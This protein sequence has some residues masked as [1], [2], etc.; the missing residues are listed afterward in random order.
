MLAVQH[1]HPS[2]RARN[3][4]LFRGQVELDEAED[5]LA[6]L[7]LEW[8][9]LAQKRDKVWLALLRQLRQVR[10]QWL[11]DAADSSFTPDLLR[12]SPKWRSLCQHISHV[13]FHALPTARTAAAAALASRNTQRKEVAAGRRRL[14]HLFGLFPTLPTDVLTLL[15]RARTRAQKREENL[16]QACEAAAAASE[17]QL[18]HE[19]ESTL[20][21][22]DP[23]TVR[24]T[25]E[26]EQ[27]A[28]PEVTC[29][30]ATK[31]KTD[32]EEV[33]QSQERHE[34]GIGDEDEGDEG[35]GDEDEGDE[36]GVM[37]AETTD[38]GFEQRQNAQEELSDNEQENV[39]RGG[40]GRAGELQVSGGSSTD[41]EGSGDKLLGGNVDGTFSRPSLPDIYG[42]GI[43]TP[44]F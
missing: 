41:S 32:A 24:T 39:G 6:E 1:K 27:K 44:L 21:S 26:S 5:H 43:S 15:H 4:L 38:T 7:H 17:I 12:K 23:D 16:R 18:Q 34:D 40:N 30:E 20:T 31:K 19:L 29:E 42:F 10:L 22:V 37:E 8:Y 36:G 9:T 13:E 33:L 2:R 14:Q 3:V 11:R 35:D 28:S 25:T